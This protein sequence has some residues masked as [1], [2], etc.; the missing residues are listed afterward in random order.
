AKGVTNPRPVT[1]TLRMKCLL[2]ASY[3]RNAHTPAKGPGAR[4][5]AHYEPASISQRLSYFMPTNPMNRCPVKTNTP[6]PN[7]SEEAVLLDFS[8]FY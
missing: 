3:L 7:T 6:L 8:L 4:A 2:P 5:T 1:T